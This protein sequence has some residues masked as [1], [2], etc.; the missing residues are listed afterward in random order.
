MKFTFVI[1]QA[2]V[3]RCGLLGRVDVPALCVLEYIGGWFFCRKARRVVVDGREFVWLRYEH[4][5]EELPLLFNPQATVE[6]RKNQLSRL[7]DVSR[8]LLA[9]SRVSHLPQPETTSQK[10][11][12]ALKSGSKVAVQNIFPFESNE[13]ETHKNTVTI[14]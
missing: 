3:V 8:H 1:N 9:R 5:V 2:G 10:R 13:I 7:S 14:E 6:T 4:A 11:V 12:E